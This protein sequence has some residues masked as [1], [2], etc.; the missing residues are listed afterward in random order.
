MRIWAMT[1]DHQEVMSWIQRRV[2]TVDQLERIIRKLALQAEAAMKEIIHEE[3]SPEATGLT[4]ASIETWPRE[5]SSVTV[6]Y[7]VGSRTR[8]HILRW[9]DLGRDWVYPVRARALRFWIRGEKVFAM[10]ARPTQP[11]RILLKTVSRVWDNLDQIVRDE[12]D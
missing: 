5:S 11:L 6:S 12:L 2:V 4:A 3:T 8:G 7:W 1:P 9:L 10:Y